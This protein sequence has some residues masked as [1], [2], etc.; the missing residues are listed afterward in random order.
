[1]QESERVMTAAERAYR[2]LKDEI[3][4]SVLAP[5][6]AL[7][8][9][10]TA[11]RLNLSRS[12]AREAI[13][14]L[15]SEGLVTLLPGRGAFVATVSLTDALELYQLR[16]VLEPLACGLAAAHPDEALVEKLRQ[17]MQEAPKLIELGQIAAYHR[18]CEEMDRA[19]ARMAGND[20]LAGFLSA[21]W[22][23]AKR[24]R[25]IVDSDS[26]MLRDSINE[27]LQILNA[28]LERDS[29]QAEVLCRAHLRRSRQRVFGSVAG[30]DA[31][32]VT[33]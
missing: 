25:T 27:H 8:E 24:I 5:G 6:Q 12:P 16:E 21:V 11:A 33:D 3:V 13:R 2:T 14:R 9:A 10:A 4:R 15:A 28:I 1:L 29:D 19:V 31:V 22:Q 20:R 23:Q 17:A 7:P 32:L 26:D 18:L 30:W